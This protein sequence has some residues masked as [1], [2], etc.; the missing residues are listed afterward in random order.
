MIKIDSRLLFVD[1]K[2]GEYLR[3]LTVNEE[4]PQLMVRWNIP[5][6]KVFFSLMH[7]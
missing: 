5:H 7:L 3:Y 6:E 2:I 1:E 4:V